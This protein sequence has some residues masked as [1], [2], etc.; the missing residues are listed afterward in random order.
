MT[1]D[2]Q[3]IEAVRL[4]E[5]LGYRWSGIAWEGTMPTAPAE[6]LASADAMHSCLFAYAEALAG[7]TE[8]SPEAAELDAV[9]T[10]LQ[11][12]EAV[13]HPTALPKT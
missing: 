8:D 13:R 10:A 11:A 2:R 1:I 9:A 4:L 5:R 3:R 7:C 12:Y 6:L